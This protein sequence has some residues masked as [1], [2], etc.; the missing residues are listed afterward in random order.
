LVE[1]A[2]TNVIKH[3]RARRLELR[4]SQPEPDELILRIEDDGIGFDVSAVRQADIS[5]GVRSMSVRIARAGGALDVVSKPG[6]TVLT[7]RL[8]LARPEP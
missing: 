4:L 2:L 1:E 6:S 3:S 7:A 8:K 5:I